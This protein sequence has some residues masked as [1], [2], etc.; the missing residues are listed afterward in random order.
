LRQLFELLIEGVVFV[1]P[2]EKPTD[3]SGEIRFSSDSPIAI[4][5]LE[6]LFPDGTWTNVPIQRHTP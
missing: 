6:V 5:A 3:F 1:L 2:P 4:G